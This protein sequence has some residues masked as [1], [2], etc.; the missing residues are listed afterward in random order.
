[1]EG[2][3]RRG[4]LAESLRR[5]RMDVNNKFWSDP[6]VQLIQQAV[7]LRSGRR[8]LCF[9]LEFIITYLFTLYYW[10]PSGPPSWKSTCP[11]QTVVGSLFWWLLVVRKVW[12]IDDSFRWTLNQ[13]AMIK[14]TNPAEGDFQRCL[15]HFG[16]YIYISPDTNSWEMDSTV[17]MNRLGECSGTFTRSRSATRWL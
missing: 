16:P 14:S 3:D 5:E 10:V 8:L 4:L 12:S 17:V 13:S 7:H 9:G 6:I 11:Q 1:M 2:L 15:C